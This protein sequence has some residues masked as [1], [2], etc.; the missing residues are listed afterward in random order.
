MRA[1]QDADLIIKITPNNRGQPAGK[2][3]DVEL[4]FVGRSSLA[5]LKL[6]GFTIWEGRPGGGRHVLFPARQYAVKGERRSFA[7]LRPIADRNA[8]DSIRDR[9]LQAYIDYEQRA[10]DDAQ[11]SSTR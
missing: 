11:G 7:L 9:I 10:G 8:Q 2:L 4:H 6:I 1:D 5:G 3:A